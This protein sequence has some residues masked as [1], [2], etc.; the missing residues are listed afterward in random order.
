YLLNLLPSGDA[1][2]SSDYLNLEPAMFE[3]GTWTDNGDNSATVEITGTL[4]EEYDE[5]III[6]L[7]VGEYGELIVGEIYLYPVEILSYLSDDELDSDT[8]D[9][10]GDASSGD[11]A[12][13]SDES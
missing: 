9:D 13:G 6:E 1:S 7:A 8:G 3:V 10:T 12:L 4:D 11:D 2:L 5:T